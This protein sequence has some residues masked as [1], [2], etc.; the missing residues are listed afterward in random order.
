M[1]ARKAQRSFGSGF[2]NAGWLAACLRDE[3]MFAR[4]SLYRT[5]PVWKPVFEPDF[6]AMSLVG[7]SVVKINQAVPGFFTKESLAEMTGMT[8]GE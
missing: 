2:L 8:A 1:T 7:D 5:Q 3:F 4:R 6:A